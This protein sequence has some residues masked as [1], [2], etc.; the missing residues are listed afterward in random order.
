MTGGYV[1]STEA[2]T[3]QWHH[4]LAWHDPPEAKTYISIND[5]SPQYV[6]NQFFYNMGY[7]VCIGSNMPTEY[8]SWNGRIGP[9]AI[10]DRVL[11]PG[12]RQAV[13]NNGN[14]ATYPFQY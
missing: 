14:G 4:V 1:E 6:E 9:V 2:T 7:P 3:G 11:T 10:W 12:E 13:Y 5:G 8:M